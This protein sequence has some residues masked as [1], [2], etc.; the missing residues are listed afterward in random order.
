MES[1]L[2]PR[3]YAPDGL[4]DSQLGAPTEASYELVRRMAREEGLLTGISSGAAIW[5]ALEIGR[6]LEHGLVV[7]VLPD[8]RGRYLS[9]AHLWEAP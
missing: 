5:A 1:A 6:R 2:V 7:A 8:G 9:D 3:I 4:M